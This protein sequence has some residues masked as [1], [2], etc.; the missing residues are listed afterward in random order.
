MNLSKF[1][2]GKWPRENVKN[3]LWE[4]VREIISIQANDLWD[5]RLTALS[6][7]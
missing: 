6:L 5:S 4:N 1:S 3:K 2:L 7:I